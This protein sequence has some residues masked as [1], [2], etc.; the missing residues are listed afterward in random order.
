MH[1]CAGSPSKKLCLDSMARTYG[2]IGL[3]GCHGWG[4][5]RWNLGKAGLLYTVG[6]MICLRSSKTDGTTIQAIQK[7]CPQAGASDKTP[8]FQW[9]Y[10]GGTIRPRAY[11][12]TC[13]DR[14]GLKGGGEPTCKP[15]KTV[16]AGGSESEAAG[17]QWVFAIRKDN[18]R[19]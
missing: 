6:E 4:N 12:G 2:P 8:E 9:D 16:G 1:T 5:Q 11:P 10:I 19:G 18:G 7:K 17:Q 3:Y 15:C 13:L 14:T